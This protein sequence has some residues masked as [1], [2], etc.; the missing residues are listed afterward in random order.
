MT[1]QMPLHMPPRAEVFSIV[2][3]KPKRAS[4]PKS[5]IGK[6]PLS[7][8][9]PDMSRYKEY[10]YRLA[11]YQKYLVNLQNYKKCITMEISKA[12]L[13]ILQIAETLHETFESNIDRKRK[14]DL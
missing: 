10:L 11:K 6:P 4:K 3:A 5:W 9:N 1:S 13:K 8:L 12:K 7:P 14:R 2:L